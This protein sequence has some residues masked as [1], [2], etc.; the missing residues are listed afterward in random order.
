MIWVGL[1]TY[2]DVS[3]YIRHLGLNLSTNAASA[4]PCSLQM[5]TK[6][7]HYNANNK[8]MEATGLNTW[9]LLAYVA[10]KVIGYIYDNFY[11]KIPF[12]FE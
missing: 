3:I 12:M 4:V 11:D 5:E 10:H 1:I 9:N 7:A 6:I 8:L 2:C